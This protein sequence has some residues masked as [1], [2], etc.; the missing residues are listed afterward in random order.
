MKLAAYEAWMAMEERAKYCVISSE[1]SAMMVRVMALMPGEHL[2]VGGPEFTLEK[3]ED[4]MA[5]MA[6]VGDDHPSKMLGTTTRV[7]TLEEQED[8]M[9]EMALELYRELLEIQIEASRIKLIAP[10]IPTSYIADLAKAN[11]DVAKTFN[12]IAVI[13]KTQKKYELAVYNFK[14]YLE[15]QIKYVGANNVDVANTYHKIACLYYAQKKYEMALEQ[16]EK[17]LALRIEARLGAHARAARSRVDALSAA[18][19][20]GAPAGVDQD[21]MYLDEARLDVAEA[22]NNIAG[23]YKAQ[24]KYEMAVEVY[25]D[26]L[27]TQ[28]MVLGANNLDVAKTYHKIACMYYAQKK[29]EMA[30]EQYEKC[31][32]IRIA[33]SGE[34]HVDVFNTTVKMEEVRI[35]QHYAGLRATAAVLRRALRAQH[36]AARARNFALHYPELGPFE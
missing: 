9:H 20:G 4:V 23:I 17:C 11:L 32:A 5:V 36:C 29:Y 25:E 3:Q 6:R 8:V 30:L 1:R 2:S 10:W 7:V 18:A 35:R 15:I 34:N 12:K 16:Y 33:V 19:M 21:P 31:L 14:K 27:M 13:Y 22:Y 24:G 28:R 26:C